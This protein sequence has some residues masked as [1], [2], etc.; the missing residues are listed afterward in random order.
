MT[1]QQA[2]HAMNEK[3]AQEFMERLDAMTDIEI[4]QHLTDKGCDVTLRQYPEQLEDY[5]YDD[6]RD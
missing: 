2:R 6:S 4:C 1:D 3:M 5:D